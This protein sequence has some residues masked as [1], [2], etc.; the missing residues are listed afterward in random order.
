M[1]TAELTEN[2]R[3][4]EGG[5]RYEMLV[6]PTSTT[7]PV[8]GAEELTSRFAASLEALRIARL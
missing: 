5:A 3:E 4:Y 8:P 7:N 2:F 1:L 6:R